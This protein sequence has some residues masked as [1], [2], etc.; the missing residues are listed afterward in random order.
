MY[1]KWLV[2]QKVLNN[3]SNSTNNRDIFVLGYNDQRHNGKKIRHNARKFEQEF[4]KRKY[5]D[6][7]EHLI[8]SCSGENGNIIN[9]CK[10]NK[11]IF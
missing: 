1:K 8:C 6:L 11:N 2:V 7:P 3:M 10:G 4:K 5:V 9:N